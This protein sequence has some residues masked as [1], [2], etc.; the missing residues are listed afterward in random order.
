M[1]PSVKGI[2][3]PQKRNT[4]PECTKLSGPAHEYMTV[5]VIHI[6]SSIICITSSIIYTT[7]SIVYITGSIL[8][9]LLAVRRKEDISPA[10][11]YA[12]RETYINT[13]RIKNCLGC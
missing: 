7:S 9:T 11:I 2:G 4:T 10:K 3:S 13:T 1:R 8:Y 12:L 5:S 6:T